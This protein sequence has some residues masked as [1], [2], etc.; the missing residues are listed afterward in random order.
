MPEAGGLFRGGV[1]KRHLPAYDA[2]GLRLF[3]RETRRAELAHW[4]AHVLR[5]ALR[6]VEPAAR[7][8]RCSSATACW[9]TCRSS[10]IQRY[11]RF[12]IQA[13]LERRHHDGP[14]RARHGGCSGARP[15]HR[16]AV[17]AAA[18]DLPARSRRPAAHRLGAAQRDPARLRRRAVDQRPA[19]GRAT[20]PAPTGWASAC[21]SPA[22]PTPTGP[23]SAPSR[24]SGSRSGWST[25]PRTGTTPPPRWS[26]SPTSSP[27][28]WSPRVVWFCLRD[29]FAAWV[30]AVLT[31]TTLGVG[32]YVVYPAA[33]PWLASDAGRDRHRGPDLQPRLGLPAP[34]PA[35]AG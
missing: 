19:R 20:A 12:R 5:A 16:A 25:G 26:T 7:G 9:S 13:L 24:R 14:R 8:R 33:P 23:S 27:S 1:S 35:S 2:A 15:P 10:S 31:F 29:R 28:R 17:A 18:R 34:G 30:A 3:V 21:T 32:G 11:N 4:W 6:A 22:R